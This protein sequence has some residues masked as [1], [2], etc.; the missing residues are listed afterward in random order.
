MFAQPKDD[1]RNYAIAIFPYPNKKSPPKRASNV[2][3]IPP[4]PWERAGERLYL[5]FRTEHRS[6]STFRK[7]TYISDCQF[8]CSLR[9]CSFYELRYVDVISSREVDT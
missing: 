9:V 2:F 8:E 4:S 7:A 1:G 3:C 5:E 6:R